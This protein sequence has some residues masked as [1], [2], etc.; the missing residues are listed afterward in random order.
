MLFWVCAIEEPTKKEREEQNKL[1]SIIMQPRVV[2]AK[3]DE[4]AAIKVVE[5]AEELKSKDLDKVQ[6]IV[7][8]F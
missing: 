5:S 6:V 4:S 1:E 2:V 8:P 3:D 7:R